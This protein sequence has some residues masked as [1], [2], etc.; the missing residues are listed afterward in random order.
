[1]PPG[2]T[3]NLL[4]FYWCSWKMV[5]IINVVHSFDLRVCISR[6]VHRLFSWLGYLGGT[7]MSV[8]RSSSSH[9]HLHTFQTS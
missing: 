1:M 9:T 2:N 8:G 4:E 6:A 3:G 7:V 5:I